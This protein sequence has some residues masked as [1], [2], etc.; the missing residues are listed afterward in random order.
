MGK[1]IIIIQG[2]EVAMKKSKQNNPRAQMMERL[3]T[4]LK[5]LMRML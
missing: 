1:W 2:K 5:S 3:H 4:K